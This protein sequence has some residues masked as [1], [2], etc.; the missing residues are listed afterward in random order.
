MNDAQ[1]PEVVVT[2]HAAKRG[3]KRL[4]LSPSAVEKIASRA[5]RDGHWLTEKLVL[6]GQYRVAFAF[7]PDG[8]AVVT[9]IWAYHGNDL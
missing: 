3:K 2:K 7:R 6:Y 4:R 8:T 1:A 9:S 5:L